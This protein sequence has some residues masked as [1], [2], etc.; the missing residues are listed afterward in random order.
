M[1]GRMLFTCGTLILLSPIACAQDTAGDSQ[2]GRG[3]VVF[4]PD[5]NALSLRESLLSPIQPV[6]NDQS[7]PPNIVLILAD[8]LGY[9]DIGIHGSKSIPTPHID[10]LARDGVRF[11]SAYVTAASCSPS[12]AGLLTGRYQQRYGFEFNTA[13]AAITHRLF[14]GL[15]PS[16]VTLADV[17]R[18]GGYRTA[19]FGKWHLGTREHLHP[20]SRGFDEYFGFLG[21]AHS[22]FP[23]K[24]PEPIYSTITRGRAPLI[25]PE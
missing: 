4:P 3:R 20:Q 25:E 23:A 10:S 19:A 16:A 2:A 11:S 13:G 21:G 1:H 6:V 12:R 17:L 7:R 9:A 22:F 18:R 8:D 5:Q 15:D 14:R 24:S